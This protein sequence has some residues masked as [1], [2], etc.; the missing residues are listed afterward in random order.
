[1]A[2]IDKFYLLSLI[3]FFRNNA[4]TF[5]HFHTGMDHFYLVIYQTQLVD[6]A[7]CLVQNRYIEWM[8]CEK[9]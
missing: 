1:M 6:Y 8:E 2:F 9:T 7:A 3:Y 5:Y 4:Y